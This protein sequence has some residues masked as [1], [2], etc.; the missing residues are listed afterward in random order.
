MTMDKK[1]SIGSIIGDAYASIMNNSRYFST[2]AVIFISIQLILNY[3]I[4][5]NNTGTSIL[6]TVAGLISMLVYVKLAVMIHRSIL[7]NEY[8]LNKLIQFS[9]IEFKFIGWAV[10]IYLML[11]APLGILMAFLIPFITASNDEFYLVG[12]FAIVGFAIV[13]FIS[14]QLA[15]LFPNVAI[16]KQMSLADAWK[17][18]RNNRIT[19]FLL[20]MVIPSVFKILVSFMSTNHGIWYF[21]S[22]IISVI[23]VIFEVSILSHCYQFLTQNVKTVMGEDQEK[24]DENEEINQEL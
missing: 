12:V 24:P 14:S 9:S 18:T 16:S 10:V 5:K 11:F 8:N 1:I 15:L 19:L 17:L 21:I 22:S 23:I 7:L 3:L 6:I 20:I 4:L 2:L 13:L